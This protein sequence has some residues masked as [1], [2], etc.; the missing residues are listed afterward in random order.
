[1]YKQQ[2]EKYRSQG[3]KNEQRNLILTNISS[4]IICEVNLACNT[5]NACVSLMIETVRK[6]M[7]FSSLT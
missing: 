4:V 3:K 6:N 1:M 2:Y 7:A 5:F